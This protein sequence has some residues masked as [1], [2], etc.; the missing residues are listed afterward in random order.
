[1]IA[2]LHDPYTEY[3]TPE[4]YGLLRRNLGASYSGIGVSLTPAAGGFSVVGVQ[5]GP[6]AAAG[7][8]VGD[9]I[10]R[11]DRLR[12]AGLGLTAALSRIAGPPGSVVDLLVRRGDKLRRLAIHRGDVRTDSVSARLVVSRDR[13]YG[14]VRV[15]SFGQDTAPRIRSQL[16]RLRHL[17]ASGFVLDLRGNPG[18]LLGQAV[19][20][21]SY[22]LRN[23]SAVVAIEGAHQPRRAFR[24]TGSAFVQRLPVV[25]LVDRSSASSAEVLAAALQ[26]DHRAVVVGEPTFGKAL[27]QA[28][29]PLGNGSALSLT[30]ARYITPSGSDISGRGVRPNIR[31]VDNPRTP[32]D[33]ALAAALAAL[34]G[35]RS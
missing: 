19:R 17:G 2:A 14:V 4:A 28:L 29:Y 9:S 33:E 24:A 35:V 10:V 20:S 11:I 22:F 18:G 30:T 23:G 7:L 32:A 3:L 21:A 5:D 25:V 15:S 8:R 27:V 13:T 34:G 6:G 31:A 1:M 12:A 16:G 26:D